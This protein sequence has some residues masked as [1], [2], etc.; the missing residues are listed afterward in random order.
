MRNAN[1]QLTLMYDDSRLVLDMAMYS[2]DIHY[3]YGDGSHDDDV[4]QKMRMILI[5][6]CCWE[7]FC[8]C[9]LFTLVHK[10]VF[11]E[12]SSLRSAVVE[13]IRE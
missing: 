8:Y 3:H 10:L 7:P 13:M 12:Y 4:L 9:I 1:E 6:Y 11:C 5:D 2:Y